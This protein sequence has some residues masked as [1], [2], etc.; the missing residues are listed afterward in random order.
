M[1]AKDKE[2]QLV[3]IDADAIQESWKLVYRHLGL[4]NLS[5]EAKVAIRDVYFL[6]ADFIFGMITSKHPD[7]P[8]DDHEAQSVVKCVQIDAFRT[9]LRRFWHERTETLHDEPAPVSEES[10]HVQ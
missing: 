2:E 4:A 7:V 9:E 8:A 3:F 6:G 1:P 10:S 5:P